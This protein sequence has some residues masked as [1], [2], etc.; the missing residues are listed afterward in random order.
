MAARLAL[1]VL[2]AACV[3]SASGDLPSSFPCCLPLGA[4]MQLWWRPPNAS[5]VALDFALTGAVPEGEYLAFGP[6]AAGATNR[7]MGSADAA[8]C[9]WDA[10]SAAPWAADVFL[11]AYAPCDATARSGVCLDAVFGGGRRN[12]VTLLSGSRAGGVTTVLLRRPLAAG[13][14]ADVALAPAAPSAFVWAHGPL[15]GGA[16]PPG[17]RLAQHGNDVD[18]YGS[19]TSLV[20]AAC[21][22]VAC[23]PLAGA[24]PAPPAP[25]TQVGFFAPIRLAG[26]GAT[27]S[28]RLHDG[29]VT[30]TARATQAS[31]WL[32][33]AVGR[34]M[35]GAHAYVAWRSAAG[36]LRVDSYDMASLAAAGLTRRTDAE[37]SL[38]SA[39]A[40]SDA[41][42]VL[43]LSFFRP[44]AS[45]GGGVPALDAVAVPLLWAV[46]PAWGA[47][48]GEGARHV[49]RS[50]APTVL[51]LCTGAAYEGAPP[52]L[53][54][55]LAA[56]GVLMAVAFAKLVPAAVAVARFRGARWFDIHRFAAFT[57]L[58]LAVIGLAGALAGAPPGGAGRVLRGA[59]GR[60][61]GAALLLMGL[62]PLNAALRPAP[63]PRGQRRVAWEALHRAGAIG[64]A[65]AAVVALF[66]GI[67]ASAGR[68]VPATKAASLTNAL[69]LWL[70]GLAAAWVAREAVAWRIRHAASPRDSEADTLS[71]AEAGGAEA[72]ADVSHAGARKR[73]P[74]DGASAARRA[75]A[76]CL[77]WLALLALL[78]AL[79]AAGK[80]RDDGPP[81]PPRI[82]S[83]LDPPPAAQAVPTGA[84][85]PLPGC[86]LTQPFELARLGDGWCDA[87]PPYNTAA[88][89][90]DGGD[91]CA[92]VASPGITECL[93]PG[94]ARVGTESPRGLRFP[95]PTNPRYADALAGRAVS[96]YSLVTSYNNF[97]EFVSVK[98]VAPRVSAAA[99]T[100]LT[101]GASSWPVVIEGAVANPLTLDAAAVAAALHAERR[102][103]RLRCV[104]A[105]SLVVPW[106]GFPLRKLLALAQPLPGAAY[107]TFES[108]VDATI[109]PGQASAPSGFGAAPWP[110]YEAITFD[111]AMNDLTFI[112]LGQFNATLKPQSGAPLRLLLPWKYGFKSVKSIT[113]IRVLNA[114]AGGGARPINWWQ[115]IAPSEYGFWANVNPAFRH[116]RWSQATESALADAYAGQPRVPTTLYNGYG[117]EV[118]HMYDASKREFFY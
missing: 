115:R 29:G 59:H 118:G 73:G 8:A 47:P 80:L 21:P 83:A 3:A 90:W 46:G 27:L 60:A 106:E 82:V 92:V 104:E 109:A 108:F 10:T 74:P 72:A 101:L 6:A 44:L 110:Y 87:G 75:D 79:L 98:A 86:P 41:S 63:H 12:D 22:P 26:G 68:G 76:A 56:H 95:A 50:S 35:T 112:A 117:G 96:A 33:L 71:P 49:A 37:P 113:R 39:N 85:S 57:A 61:G 5:A 103:Y 45:P 38:A 7:L 67:S 53:P 24:P 4:R 30:F 107:V 48:P 99:T 70:A 14:A 78:T 28:W 69:A 23:T 52:P 77:V 64:L 105:W 116:P 54:D 17:G 2:F 62:Q 13:D 40:S 19:I 84:A 18:S 9:G 100:K 36:E 97:Y 1:V 111:E 43:T 20:L 102:V 31:D 66:T 34:G 93:D 58:L 65:I 42:G 32:S 16:G 25:P 91:C 88:C 11:E 114:T 81:P 15:A 89:G 55:A 94:S 51:D